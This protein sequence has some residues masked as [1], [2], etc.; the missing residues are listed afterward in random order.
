[1]LKLDNVTLLTLF[2]G[3]NDHSLNSIKSMQNCMNKISFGE[4]VI[5]TDG[6]SAKRHDEFIQKHDIK[7]IPMQDSI[8]SNLKDDTQR[9]NFSNTFLQK[10]KDSVETEFCLNIQSDSTIIDE[11]K[12]TDNFLEYDYIGAP[13]PEYILKTSDMCQDKIKWF[14]NV[15]G[16]GG[17]SIRS[18]RFIDS[19]FNLETFHK[20]EDLNVCIFNY[21]NMINR[22]VKFA[23]KELAYEFSV[24]HPI[25][26]LGSYD[27]NIL[28]TYKSFGFHG[29]FNPAGMKKIL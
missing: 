19:C 13:W 1:M 10:L 25:N 24:E 16:N 4:K 6:D 21:Y 17:F 3:D 2:W 5:I 18:K 22:G 8:S 27:R 28:S 9:E 11:E 12:W 7:Y 23:P 20:N 26:T 15:V 14:P 29:D